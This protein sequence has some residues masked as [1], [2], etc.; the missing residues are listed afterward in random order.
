MNLK[1]GC[2]V[3]WVLAHPHSLS[4]AGSLWIKSALPPRSTFPFNLCF[5][6]TSYKVHL[7]FP[8]CEMPFSVLSLKPPPTAHQQPCK[9][10]TISLTEFS[11][12]LNFFHFSPTNLKVQMVALVFSQLFQLLLIRIL[13]YLMA[14]VF[15]TSTW[16]IVAGGFPWVWG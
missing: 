13:L 10:N 14:Q 15:N 3:F 5:S 1:L 16:E 6:R 11:T 12:I 8:A 7:C 4:I 2:D 9:N